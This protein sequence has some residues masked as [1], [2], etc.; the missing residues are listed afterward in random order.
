[1]SNFTG[2]IKTHFGGGVGDEVHN[3]D[4]DFRRDVLGYNTDDTTFEV[5]EFTSIRDLYEKRFGDAVEKY[6]QSQI[7]R[8]HS[9]RQI[10]DYYEKI[11]NEEIEG[12]KRKAETGSKNF[13]HTQYEMIVGV[14]NKKNHPSPDETK[15]IYQEFVEWF[16]NR[17]PQFDINFIS[18]QADEDGAPEVQMGFVPFATDCTR[19]PEVQNSLARCLKQMGYSS[20]KASEM[21][22]ECRNKLQELCEARG[23]EIIHPQAGTNTKSVPTAVY[24]KMKDAENEIEE[25][26]TKSAK[27]EQEK[28][29]YQAKAEKDANETYK[30]KY[31]DAFKKANADLRKQFS[32]QVKKEVDARM[33]V[34]RQNLA[35]DEEKLKK[36]R[37]ILAQQEKALG[38]KIEALNDLQ[39]YLGKRGLERYVQDHRPDVVE[40]YEKFIKERN[41]KLAK[42][43]LDYRTEQN[44]A[45]QGY[46]K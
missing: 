21:T 24:K 18:W 28:K 41:D 22:D 45:E 44:S 30:K 5:W 39:T 40:D 13:R 42:Q 11:L 12:E 4:K 17:H 16:K 33:N 26:A 6:N 10:E 35:S 29:E 1:M 32:E 9:E 23:W 31:S 36:D 19:G 37:D 34:E 38:D 27:L 3:V 7:D 8:C 14:G 46:E 15:I 25:Y 2:T 20:G 43:D